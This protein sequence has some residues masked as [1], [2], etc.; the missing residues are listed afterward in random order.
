M[1]RYRRF[2]SLFSEVLS[3]QVTQPGSS[4]VQLGSTTVSLNPRGMSY[5]YL[6]SLFPSVVLPPDQSMTMLLDASDKIV[7]FGNIV[8]NE[9]QKLTYLEAKPTGPPAPFSTSDSGLLWGALASLLVGGLW[10]VIAA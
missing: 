8:D 6:T 9:T 7:S 3:S 2:L 10:K 5:V 1:G 4:P